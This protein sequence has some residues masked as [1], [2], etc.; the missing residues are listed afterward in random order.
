MKNKENKTG[1]SFSVWR[2]LV[3]LIGISILLSGAFVVWATSTNPVMNTDMDALQSD[4]HVQVTQ[5]PWIVFEPKNTD[6]DTGVI[7]YPGG[8]VDPRA[9]APIMHSLAKEGYL[10]IVVPMPLNLAFTSINKAEEVVSAYP[11]VE[12]WIISGHSLGGAMAS[13][14]VYNNP[15]QM[16]GLI[17]YASYP[18]NNNSLALTNIPVLSIYG[19]ED[20]GFEKLAA[21]TNLLP[22]D[23]KFVV[24]EGGNH[25]QFGDYGLQ[26]GDGTA[27]LSRE[28]QQTQIVNTTLE[29]LSSLGTP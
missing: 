15:D 10:T 11:T 1:N 20:G 21:S 19:T 2:I 23:T 14:Y 24:V 12:T 26:Q 4:A 9:Y 7:F 28:D 29:W 8:K 13:N 17:L 18:A 16:Q 6:P 5:A 25:A 3:G 22:G 27:R